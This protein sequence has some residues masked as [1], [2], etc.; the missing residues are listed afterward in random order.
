MC[1][2]TFP[3]MFLVNKKSA[4][5]VMLLFSWYYLLTSWIWEWKVHLNII[6]FYQF[7]H[8]MLIMRRMTLTAEKK[9]CLNV[10]P[11]SVWILF[12]YVSF[13]QSPKTCKWRTCEVNAAWQG[14]GENIILMKFHW[15][16][17]YHLCKCLHSLFYSLI[18]LEIFLSQWNQTF[19]Q[20]FLHLYVHTNLCD[21]AW[22]N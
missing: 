13:L 16:L 1:T 6:S 18:L 7:I 11:M 22:S 4:K 10:L 9:W 21:F 20:A 3:G 15:F 5:K 8:F 2:D 19:C 12:R 17:L 14:R